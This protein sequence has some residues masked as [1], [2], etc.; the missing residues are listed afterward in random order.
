MV[1]FNAKQKILC[2]LYD[3][4]VDGYPPRASSSPRSEI[5]DGAGPMPNMFNRGSG[6]SSHQDCK[7]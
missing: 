5:V 2:V 7:R 6:S 1:N 3:D 4:P